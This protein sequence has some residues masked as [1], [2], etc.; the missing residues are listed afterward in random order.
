[1]IVNEPIFFSPALEH[2]LQG[3]LATSE[4]P[5]GAASSPPDIPNANARISEAQDPN[6][7]L[8]NIAART[9][10][11]FLLEVE[12]SIAV[13]AEIR[14]VNHTLTEAHCQALIVEDGT[15]SDVLNNKQCASQ[16]LRADFEPWNLGRYAFPDPLSHVHSNTKGEPRFRL[17]SGVAVTHIEFFELLLRN[18]ARQTWQRWAESVWLARSSMTL[19]G[20][21]S[22]ETLIAVCDGFEKSQHLALAG[23]MRSAVKKWRQVLNREKRAMTS[24][25]TSTVLGVLDY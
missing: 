6:D 17:G 21:N 18:Y 15:V 9:K 19:E 13:V 5:D 8:R 22:V 11:P 14:W 3:P 20:R 24:I 23:D 16:Y 4:R 7:W 12:P 25:F 2:L 1:M 10:Y